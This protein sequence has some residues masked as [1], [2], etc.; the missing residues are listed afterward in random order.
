M[1]SSELLVLADQVSSF[2]ATQTTLQLLLALVL[3][4]LQL[5]SVLTALQ[6]SPQVPAT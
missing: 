2:F 4:Q 5:M 3:P 1:L 6:Q